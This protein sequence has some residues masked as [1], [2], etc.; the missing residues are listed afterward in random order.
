M[1]LGLY[2]LGTG[3]DFGPQAGHTFNPGPWRQLVD[4]VNLMASSLTFPIRDLNLPV[5]PTTLPSSGVRAMS[6][7]AFRPTR[8]GHHGIRESAIVDHGSITMK[9]C[10][11]I[12]LY[13]SSANDRQRSTTDGGSSA[14]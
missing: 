4:S 8:F 5:N 9:I 13:L 6:A 3:G 14:A 11:T 7:I 2:E 12:L 10:T 1:T